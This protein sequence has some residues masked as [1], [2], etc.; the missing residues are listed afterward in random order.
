MAKKSLEA[1]VIMAYKK[2]EAFRDASEPTSLE[3]PAR[4][5]VYLGN[6]LVSAFCAGMEAQKKIYAKRKDGGKWAR[7]WRN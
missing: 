6:R 4:M 2:S 7:D 1:K 5:E 3:A